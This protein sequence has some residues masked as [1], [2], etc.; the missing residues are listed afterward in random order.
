M[1]MCLKCSLSDGPFISIMTDFTEIVG[2]DQ[3]PKHRSNYSLCILK[4]NIQCAEV[5]YTPNMLCSGSKRI[6]LN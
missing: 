2:V 1:Q 4:I 5:T 3:F 6:K